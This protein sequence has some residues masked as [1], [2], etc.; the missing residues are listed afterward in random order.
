MHWPSP[1]LTFTHAS[2]N[3]MPP[4]IRNRQG[5]IAGTHVTDGAP[6]RSVKRSATAPSPHAHAGPDAVVTHCPFSSAVHRRAAFARRD[7]RVRR[8]IDHAR[9]AARERRLRALNGEHTVRGGA[10]VGL[11]RRIEHHILGRDPRGDSRQVRI[12]RAEH[13][14]TRRP[15]A[16]RPATR[17]RFD[18]TR[19]AGTRTSHRYRSRSSPRCRRRSTGHFRCA[20]ATSRRCIIAK[21]SPP[22]S[23]IVRANTIG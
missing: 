5:S 21:P 8:L 14:S 1:Q 3:V 19:R 4:R 16:D 9:A 23:S 10:V 11:E 20:T 17:S 6:S 15:P 18:R 13:R 12:R 2:G 22:A 7:L